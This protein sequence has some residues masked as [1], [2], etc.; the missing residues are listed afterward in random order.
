VNRHIH[1]LGPK[2]AEAIQKAREDVIEA[3]IPAYAERFPEQFE[4]AVETVLT[5]RLRE[6]G[7]TDG[8]SAS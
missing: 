8:A 6:Q 3:V 2:A 5:F 1:R 7:C 4:H